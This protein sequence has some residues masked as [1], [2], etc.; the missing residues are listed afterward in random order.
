MARLAFGVDVGGTGIKAGLVDL[1]RGRLRG[2]RI[3]ME[4]PAGGEPEAIAAAVRSMLENSGQDW[5]HLPIGI[6]L[7]SVVVAGVTKSAAN[8]SKRWLGLDA[9]ELFQTALGSRVA[10]LNDADAAGLAEVRFGAALGVRGTV[11]VVTL[12]TGIGTALF[13]NGRLVPNLELGHIEIDGK[14]AESEASFA[15]KE[16][17]GLSFAD[18]ARRLERYFLTL[19]K[20]VSPGLIIVGGGVSKQHSEF[21]PLLKL[22]TP[23]VPA[24]HRNSAGIIGAAARAAQRKS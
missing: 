7:P 8:V 19:E 9:Q 3:R 6:C 15:A 21:L 4:T 5:L 17:A 1:R 10:L 12:G 2:E 16:R 13:H 11:L 14:D 22:N 18:W 24:Q 20:L 23:I